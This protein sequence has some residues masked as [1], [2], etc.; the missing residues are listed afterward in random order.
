MHVVVPCF[1]LLHLLSLFC[2][3]QLLRSNN[4]STNIPTGLLL[5]GPFFP[6]ENR[7]AK[8]MYHISCNLSC[9]NFHCYHLAAGKNSHKN[10]RV[11]L[12][13]TICS[14]LLIISVSLNFL[15][16]SWFSSVKSLVVCQLKIKI[17]RI[18]A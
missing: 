6:G 4:R 16:I 18:L 9:C 10:V 2:Q 14:M 11:V 3:R 15:P 1:V 12:D 5:V 13:L 7:I 8:W 17:I